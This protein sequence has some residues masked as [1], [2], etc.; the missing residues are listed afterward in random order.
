MDLRSLRHL[1]VLAKR[2]NYVRATDELRITQPALS[3]SIQAL[4]RELAV[5]LFDRDRGSVRLTPQGRH[6]SDLA[7]ALLADAEEIENYCRATAKGDGGRIR[8]GMAPMPA[9][10]LLPKVLSERLNLA[11]TVSNEILVRDAEALWGML[12]GG[13]IEFFIS[14]D[15]PY[16]DPQISN[17]ELLG[18][19]P[20]SLIV[21][22]KHPL[23]KSK[24]TGK[25][26]PLLRAS[27]SSLSIPSEIQHL[28]SAAANVVEDFAVL[29]DVTAGTDAIWM[30]S[31]YAI[32]TKLQDGSLKELWRSPQKI[33]I[34][35][36]THARRSQSPS[37]MLIASMI[38]WQV[39]LLSANS[40]T[41]DSAQ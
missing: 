39:E 35:I 23:L 5:R 15:Y 1:I 14:P 4:E 28:I 26:F 6:I 37:A 10:V 21:R 9:Q 19:I 8:F 36:Y 3:R 32:E 41:L 7:M 22:A 34:K 16:Y 17:V 40:C 27:W 29:A 38:R 20:L 24:K 33:E 11:P 13:E 25:K 12:L 18:E 2:L 31:A 30:S